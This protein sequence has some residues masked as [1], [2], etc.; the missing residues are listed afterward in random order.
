M[1]G[2]GL[3]A[4]IVIAVATSITG[5]NSAK[6]LLTDPPELAPSDVEHTLHEFFKKDSIWKIEE[7]QG[8]Y[9]DSR[10]TKATAHFTVSRTPENEHDKNTKKWGF[11]NLLYFKNRGWILRYVDID[12]GSVSWEA[13]WRVQPSPFVVNSPLS[14]PK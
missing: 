4:L 7:F 9:Q 3:I 11:A 14:T 2:I 6:N 1:K 5:A 10:S 12:K 8:L 13:H